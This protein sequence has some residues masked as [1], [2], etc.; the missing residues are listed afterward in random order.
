MRSFLGD[1]ARSLKA[2]R[3]QEWGAKKREKDE[4]E[5]SVRENR[6]SV[7]ETD[8]RSRSPHRSSKSA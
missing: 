1:G 4:R 8:P 5:F 3:D 6:T 7:A 2:S